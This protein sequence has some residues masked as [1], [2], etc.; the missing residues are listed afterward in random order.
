MLSPLADGQYVLHYFAKDCAGTEELKFAQD[1][2]GSWSTNFYTF[3]INVDTAA[4]V[5]ATG[6]TLSAASPYSQGQVVTATFSCTDTLSGVVQCGGQSFPAG[7][8]N[9]G[10]ITVPVNTATAGPQNFSVVATDAA[11]NQSAAATVPYTVT[12][13]DTQIQ[14]TLSPATITYPLGTNVVVTVAKINSHV[15]TGTV[16]I[17]ENGAILKSL[18]LNGAG[19]AYYY[20]SGLSAGNHS[21]TAVYSGDKNNVAGSSAPVV[22]KVLP[23][24][25]SLSVACWNTPYP[26]GANFYC[27]VNASSNAGA[28]KGVITYTYDGAAPVSMPL[29]GGSANIVLSKPPVGSHTVSISYPAQ[30]NYDAAGPKTTNFVVT[31]APVQIQ[32]TPSSWYLTGGTLKLT[33]TVQ[34]W[35]AGPPNGIGQVTFTTGA[36]VLGSAPV[37]AAGVASISIPATALPNGSD[38]LTA[39]YSGGTNYGTGATSVT[40]QVAH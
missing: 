27:N 21:L 13:A 12:E 31:A 10:S 3:P 29:N 19:S 16:Q 5:V 34:S 14:L 15:P 8:L 6:P 7:T 4:P 37:N 26:Y 32:F 24:P 11:G 20:L 38:T 40:I 22:L 17:V 18:A 39:T 33:A 23:V 1:G 2:T 36:T 9:T 35:S 28:A 25:V 30:T